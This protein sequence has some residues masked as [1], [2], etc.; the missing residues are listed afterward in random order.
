MFG[1]VLWKYLHSLFIYLL[2]NMS[3]FQCHDIKCMKQSETRYVISW[4]MKDIGPI[5]DKQKEDDGSDINFSF[6]KWQT[7]GKIHS[8]TLIK[9]LYFNV[10]FTSSWYK[11]YSFLYRILLI[12]LVL[13]FKH[14]F[15]V[16][17]QMILFEKWYIYTIIAYFESKKGLWVTVL[18]LIVEEMRYQSSDIRSL[19]I[20]TV[21]LC[22]MWKSS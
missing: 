15:S 12:L 3:I 18:M 7:C 5:C 13:F 21:F 6:F 8:K 10:W 9:Y 20:L 2:W 14:N 1:K 4:R 11:L 17:P 19:K 22:V 16:S